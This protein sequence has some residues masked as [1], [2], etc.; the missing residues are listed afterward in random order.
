MRS[1]TL[2]RSH[3]SAASYASTAYQVDL[4]GLGH[5]H[6]LAIKTIFGGI[7]VVG[8]VI[9]A[10]HA[11]DAIDPAGSTAGLLEFALSS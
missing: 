6:S 5:T 9:H 7:T 10:H 1:I 2:A 4:I 8:R 3:P 11:T